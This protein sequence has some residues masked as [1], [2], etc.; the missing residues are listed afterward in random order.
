MALSNVQKQRSNSITKLQKYTKN[1]RIT[2]SL[3]SYGD[4]IWAL[5]SD[6]TDSSEDAEKVVRE[7]FLDICRDTKRDGSNN[8]DEII[9]MSIVARRHFI[10]RSPKNTPII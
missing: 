5:A 6:L 7:L 2:D 4:L 9:F 1:D 3:N 10:E 8:F